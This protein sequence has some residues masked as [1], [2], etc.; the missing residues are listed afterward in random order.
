MSNKN[1]G[2]PFVFPEWHNKVP[3]LV[4]GIIGPLA[5][6]L[7]I[8]AATY[9]LSPEFYEV[10]YEPDDRAKIVESW[11]R[12]FDDTPARRDWGWS[13]EVDSLDALTR[14]LLDEFAAQGKS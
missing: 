3:K 1:P 4:F 9:Y 10:G 5:T 2:D 8:G 11:P 14:R 6:V 13:P 12:E 7:G